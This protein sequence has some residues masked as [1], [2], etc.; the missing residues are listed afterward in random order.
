VP[1]FSE[2][3]L[4]PCERFFIPNYTFHRTFRLTGQK[5]EL[6]LH[7]K[8]VPH[9]HVDLVPLFQKMPQESAHRLE[10]RSLPCS[11]TNYKYAWSDAGITELLAI[12]SKSTLADDMNANN[13]FWRAH[14]Q[15]LQA[16]NCQTFLI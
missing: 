4:K 11:S 10:N 1:L 7:L 8:G 14:F 5:A 15:N 9:K 2:T 13:Q 3:H 16:R 6:L 12:T